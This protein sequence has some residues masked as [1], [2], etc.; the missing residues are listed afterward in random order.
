MIHIPSANQAQGQN[1]R[2]SQVWSYD[3]ELIFLLDGWPQLERLTDI[4]EES[5]TRSLGIKCSDMV[6]VAPS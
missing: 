2:F 6:S 5:G 3:G 4:T 1:C